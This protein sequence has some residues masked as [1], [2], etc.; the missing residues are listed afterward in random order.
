MLLLLTIALVLVGAVSLLIGFVQ[1]QLFPI[2]LS[3]GCSLVAAIVLLV[4]SRLSRS[5]VDTAVRR[6]T[7]TEDRDRT[8]VAGDDGALFPIED[9]DDLKVAEIMPL[10]PE[11]DYDELQEV[12]EREEDGRNR[13]TVLRRIDELSADLGSSRSSTLAETAAFQPSGDD[14]DAGDDGLGD[15]DDD[16]GFSDDDDLFP[17]EDYDDLK[18]SEILPL[19]GE[20]EDDELEDVRRRERS[21]SARATILTRIDALLGGGAPAPAPARKA[22]AKRTTT[23]AKKVPAKKAATAVKKAPAKKAPAKKAAA[24]RKSTAKKA[25]A[26]KAGAA[27]KR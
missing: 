2:Y 17:I 25:P 8:V 7:V 6:T 26:K 9:Y 1:D 12:R 13:A 14:D 15:D 20:L 27:K 22:P 24:T 16:A 10:L 3:I 11:L 4:F 5:R 19:L 18:V 21:G 23:A